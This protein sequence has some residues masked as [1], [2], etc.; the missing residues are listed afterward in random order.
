[1]IDW[2]RHGKLIACVGALA[3]VI[4]V[5]MYIAKRRDSYEEVVVGEY[6]RFLDN[7]PHPVSVPPGFELVPDRDDPSVGRGE[8]LFGNY[9]QTT[10]I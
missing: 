5:G 7:G 3:L 9:R 1:M 2:R 6:P 4:I 10:V 8:G